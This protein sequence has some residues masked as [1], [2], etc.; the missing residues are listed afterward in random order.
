MIYNVP[1]YEILNYMNNS[2]LAFSS[3]YKLIF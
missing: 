3:F 2:I 1:Q